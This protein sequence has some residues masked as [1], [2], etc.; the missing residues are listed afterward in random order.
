[1]K[2][3]QYT[4]QTQLNTTNKTARAFQQEYDSMKDQLSARHKMETERADQLHTQRV[5]EMTRSLEQLE[6]E[7]EQ[8]RAQS[9]GYQE[10]MKALEATIARMR[11]EALSYQDTTAL[12][13]EVLDL[14]T[15]CVRLRG[16]RDELQCTMMERGSEIE[17]SKMELARVKE[18]LD[19]LEEEA[20]DRITQSNEWYRN[21]QVCD[22]IYCSNYVDTALL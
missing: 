17:M 20:A 15:E 18:Q 5:N 1:M 6:S 8:A 14:H 11:E 19:R 13:S 3:E 21:L 9:H 4:L 2:Q 22:T 16:E 7:L 12:E 10:K